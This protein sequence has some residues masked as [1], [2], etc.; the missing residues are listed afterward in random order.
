MNTLQQDA[1]DFARQLVKRDLGDLSDLPEEVRNTLAN[2][3]YEFAQMNLELNRPFAF[4]STIALADDVV[5]GAKKFVK[6]AAWLTS[7]VD[8]LPQAVEGLRAIRR[9][10]SR[11]D[12]DFCVRAF[13]S[14]FK[15]RIPDLDK[16]PSWRVTLERPFYASKVQEIP[17]LWRM[18]SQ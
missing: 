4:P 16:K 1:L 15:Y 9:E 5:E 17:N 8:H 13:Q 12:Y 18:F 10:R 11:S 2:I 6:D 14:N 3:Y 7:C